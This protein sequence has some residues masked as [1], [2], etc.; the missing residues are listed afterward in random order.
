[1]AFGTLKLA[2]TDQD[3]TP[4]QAK[5]LVVYWRVYKE[6]SQSDTAAQAEVDD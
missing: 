3:I 5:Q 6:L 4:E 2:G 1:L